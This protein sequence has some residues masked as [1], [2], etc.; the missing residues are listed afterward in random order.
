MAQ[1]IIA[2]L[3]E[4]ETLS[5]L[6][7][8]EKIYLQ[9]NNFSF[10]LAPDKPEIGNLRE[11]FFLNQVSI[12]NNIKYP[13]QA[14]FLVNDRYLFE[15]GGPGKNQ[16]QIAGVSDAYLALDDIETGMENRIPLWMFGLLY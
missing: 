13:A 4:N 10:A 12:K 14:D 16:K 6:Q 3:G 1:L 8:P 5:A 11:T 9:N 15:I 7:R 2:L